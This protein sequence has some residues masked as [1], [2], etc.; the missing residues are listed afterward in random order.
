MT[1][2]RQN[3]QA[4]R[5]GQQGGHAQKNQAVQG[6]MGAERDR[7]AQTGVPML[8]ALKWPK[9]PVPGKR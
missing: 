1:T 9:R 4:I 3:Q 2:Q 5:E 8:Q 7:T 6:G